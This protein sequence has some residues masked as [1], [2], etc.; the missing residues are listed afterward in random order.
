MTTGATAAEQRPQYADDADDVIP[1][2]MINWH[3]MTLRCETRLMRGLE[4]D[5][6]PACAI[7]TQ[8]SGEASGQVSGEA[9]GNARATASGHGKK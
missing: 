5:E 9:P 4:Q 7:E 3:G 2:P 1:P 6:Q 8:M